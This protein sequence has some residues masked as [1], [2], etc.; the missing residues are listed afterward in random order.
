MNG[1]EQLSSEQYNRK[2]MTSICLSLLLAVLTVFFC[3][4]VADGIFGIRGLK[5]RVVIGQESWGPVTESWVAGENQTGVVIFWIFLI[6]LPLV[7]SRWIRWHHT[8]V[9]VFLYPAMWLVVSACVQSHHG[10][11]F[12]NRGVGWFSF[13]HFVNPIRMT[14]CFF[15]VHSLVFLLVYCFRKIHSKWKKS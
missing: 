5:H 9:N 11:Y 1:K 6:S 15:V 13:E 14:V 8:L 10:H 2:M 4:Y 3:I 7:F 12:L